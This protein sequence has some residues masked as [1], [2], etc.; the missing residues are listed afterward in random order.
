MSDITCTLAALGLHPVKSCGALAPREA[1]LVETGFDLDRAWMVV[2]PQGEMLTQREHPKLAL[3]KPTLR[4]SD[5]LLKAPGM[6]GLHLALDA[7]ETATR[8]RVW[9]DI[10]KAWDMGN[11]AAQW[12]SDYLGTPAR[13][14]RFDP[15]ETRL[16]DRAW[17][18]EAEAPVE[19]ADGF[20][21]LVASLDSL[22]DLNHRLAEAGAA[23]VTMARFRPNLVLSGLQPWD[24]DHLD[25]LE[26][27][28]DDG[29]VR[30]K[31]VKPCGRCQIP[32]VDP[33]TGEMQR[34]P[35][36]T[37][38]GFRVDGRVKGAVTFGMNA[39]VLDG[40]GRTLRAG[41]TVRA[42]FAV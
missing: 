28:T 34:E 35:G 37:L 6:L 26:I 9:D 36:R 12:F 20:P 29:P 38:A 40:A 33:A 24:E 5:L 41:Q 8:V 18:G 30:L 15:D 32:N 23:P 10:V 21:L 3:V 16:A 31:L 22:G 4:L 19:F 1:L 25:V 27:D 42:S 7:V 2:D 11:L 17:T 13:V 14:V 39:I